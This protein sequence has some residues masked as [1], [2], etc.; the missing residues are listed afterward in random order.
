[1]LRT[2]LGHWINELTSA[3]LICLTGSFISFTQ[4]L[5]KLCVIFSSSKCCYVNLC[6]SHFIKLN[7]LHI[8]IVHFP[9]NTFLRISKP[10]KKH[11][12]SCCSHHWWNIR[13]FKSTNKQTKKNPLWA[14]CDFMLSALSFLQN[15]DM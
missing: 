6:K 15:A 10:G 7:H 12:S 1:M 2:F 9:H 13:S 4:W 8:P 11:L 3:L 14:F 5:W